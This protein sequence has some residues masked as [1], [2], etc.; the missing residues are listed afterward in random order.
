MHKGTDIDELTIM[1]KSVD[2]EREKKEGASDHLLDFNDEIE[3][4]EEMGELETVDISVTGDN[5][6]YCNDILTKNSFGVAA[7][8]DLIL[9]AITTE[10]LDAL[11]Q[12]MIKQLKNRYNDVSKNRR[13]VI[14][15]DRSRMKWF[16]AEQSAQEGIVDDR[17][18]FDK[19]G[20]GEADSDRTATRRSKGFKKVEGLM[21]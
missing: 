9:A 14:G 8:A 10:E 3:T 12:V 21:V 7:V 20:F 4:I 11:G 17:P 2:E 6:Y 16:N 1:L 13:F 18:A 5:L 19:S 15:I